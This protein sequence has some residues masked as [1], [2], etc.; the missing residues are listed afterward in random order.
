[1]TSFGNELFRR[2][3][4]VTPTGLDKNQAIVVSTSTMKKIVF[5][6]IKSLFSTVYVGMALI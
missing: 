5:N 6:S 2:Y 4:R 1:M 3:N